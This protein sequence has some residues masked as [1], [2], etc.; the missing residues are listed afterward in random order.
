[1]QVSISTCVSVPSSLRW[2]VPDDKAS[3]GVL[4]FTISC[5]A[6]GCCE[7]NWQLGGVGV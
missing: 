1:M 3:S 4:C 5:A 2:V 7:L 6:A